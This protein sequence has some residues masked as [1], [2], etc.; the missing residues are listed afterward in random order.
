MDCAGRDQNRCNSWSF[1]WQFWG[2][3]AL[4]AAQTSVGGP[5]HYRFNDQQFVDGGRIAFGKWTDFVFSVDWG[6]GFYRVWR[7]DEG[8]TNFTHVLSGTTEVYAGKDIYVKQG[9]YRGGNVDG[10]TDVLWMGPTARGASF[11]AV[12]QRA[13]GTTEGIKGK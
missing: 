2:W 10:R 8:T 5:Q 11:A 1:V 9:L 6:S 3:G 7:R 13:F 12:E 4:S